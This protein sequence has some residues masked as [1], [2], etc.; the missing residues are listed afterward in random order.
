MENDRKNKWK[1][2]V[3]DDNEVNTIMLANI[4]ELFDIRSD[5]ANSGMQALKML[6]ENEYHIIFIDHIMPKMNGI[7]TTK[8]IRGLQ[9]FESRIVIIALTS[10][11]TEEVRGLYQYAGAN[12]VY[13]KPLG[14]LELGTII[15]QWCPQLTIREPLVKAP[16][17]CKEDFLIRPILGEIDEINFEIGLKYA[18]G[19]TKHYIDILDVS[20]KDIQACINVVKNG[21]QNNLL[22]EMRIGAH[23][24]KSIF[25][26]IGAVELSD[27]AKE[28]ELFLLKQDDTT[29]IE[30]NYSYFVLRVNNF[31]EKLDQCLKNYH[32][33][34]K[35]VVSDN[36]DIFVSMSKEEYEQSISNT[37]YYIKRYDYVAILKEL[38]NLIKQ[39]HPGYQRELEL[40]IEEIKDFNYES[41]LNRM[42]EL[43]N[44]IDRA[45]AC[46]LSKRK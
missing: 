8:A 9:K 3:V 31:Y 7:Q 17:P 2:L 1:A 44:E 10:N 12:D 23:N 37:I 24:V 13:T 16:R 20:L 27:L 35:S 18:I 15:K 29:V 30:V 33:I 39:G 6:E 38:K 5:Q 40:A 25:A 21:Y 19:D 42:T 22:E 43:K 26:N 34:R 14:L 46:V 36:S 32:S 11:L 28:L 41:I 4:L 45:N